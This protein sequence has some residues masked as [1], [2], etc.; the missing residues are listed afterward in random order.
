MLIATIREEECI[1]CARCLP[2]CPVDAIIGAPKF[3]HGVLNDECIGCRLCLAPCPVNCIEMI[4]SP[5]QDT[6]DTKT[7]RANKAKLR[8]VARRNRLIQKQKPLLMDLKNNPE[9][10]EKIRKEIESAIARVQ[11]KRR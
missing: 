11:L 9:M 3:L 1:G 5:I 8:Y 6:I 7:F 10:K 2:A 4:E